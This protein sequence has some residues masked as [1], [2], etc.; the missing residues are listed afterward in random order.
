MPNESLIS[1]ARRQRHETSA[2]VR[3]GLK[4]LAKRTWKT[5]RTRLDIPSRSEISDLTTRL[6]KLHVQIADIETS[7]DFS[8]ASEPLVDT[9]LSKDLKSPKEIKEKK[10]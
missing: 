6:E 8:N 9:K 1:L 3:R 4:G 7:R 2:L 10:G 5:V